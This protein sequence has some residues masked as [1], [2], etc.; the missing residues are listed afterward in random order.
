MFLVFFFLNSLRVLLDF[1]ILLL[2]RDHCR[3]IEDTQNKHLAPTCMLSHKKA[4]VFARSSAA[5]D[6]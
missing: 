3:K 2:K 6:S 1:S 5:V 4:N